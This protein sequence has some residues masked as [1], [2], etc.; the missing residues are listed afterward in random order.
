M[1]NQDKQVKTLNSE[2]GQK[3]KKENQVYRANL[4]KPVNKGQKVMKDGS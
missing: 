4:V 2:S 3:I 1:T